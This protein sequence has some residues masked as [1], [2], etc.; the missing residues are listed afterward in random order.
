[1]GALREMEIAAINQKARAARA[2]RQREDGHHAINLFIND[3]VDW[4]YVHH[5]TDGTE[6][7]F[8]IGV[9]KNVPIED[10]IIAVFMRADTE[11]RCIV[12]WLTTMERE[13]GRTGKYITT[14]SLEDFRRVPNGLK[15]AGEPGWEEIADIAG[16]ALKL[17]DGAHRTYL[18]RRCGM[19]VM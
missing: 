19:K 14:C 1:V 15:E 17:V 9:V 7:K 12:Y 13:D 5:G 10:P 3:S 4:F 18:E 2:E 11:D 6:H 8:G 16:E